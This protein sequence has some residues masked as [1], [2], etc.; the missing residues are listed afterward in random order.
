LINGFIKICIHAF[1]PLKCHL[2]IYH[3]CKAW[4]T[5]WTSYCMLQMSF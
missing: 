1:L 4:T 2:L 5:N 3:S